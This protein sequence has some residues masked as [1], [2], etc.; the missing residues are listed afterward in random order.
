G[1]RRGHR[2]RTGRRGGLDRPGDRGVRSNREPL[3][4][5]VVVIESRSTDRVRKAALIVWTII[6]ALVIL[7][8]VAWTA[9]QVRII[10]LPLVFAAGLVII[11]DPIASSVQRAGIPR[12]VGTAFAFVV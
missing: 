6:G 2:H 12:V 11:L 5:L 8:V 7:A 9:N 1:D 3:S 4:T 10:W